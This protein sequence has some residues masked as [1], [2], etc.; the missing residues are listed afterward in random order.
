MPLPGPHA[1]GTGHPLGERRDPYQAFNFVVEVEGILAG[2]FSECTGLQ[3]EIESATYPEGGVNEYVHQFWGRTKYPALV[4]RRGVTSIDALWSWYA[5]VAQG[6]IERKNGT[7]YLLDRQ[8][9]SVMAWNFS[10]A[11]PVKWTGPELRADSATV[12][13]ESVELVHRGLSWKRV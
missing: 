9:H 3:A 6:K 1:A 2:G 7:I 4:L 12:A 10:Q 8:H 11:F 13:F 5:E